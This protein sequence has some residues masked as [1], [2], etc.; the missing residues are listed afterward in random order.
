MRV[1]YEF[2]V[3]VAPSTVRSL[4]TDVERSAA[5]VPGVSLETSAPGEYGG[6]LR[7]RVG[8][9]TVTYRGTATVSMTE[10]AFRLEFEGQEARGSGVAKGAVTFALA[11]DQQR[12][13]VAVDADVTVTGRLGSLDSSVLSDAIRRLFVRFGECVIAAVAVEEPDIET[14]VGPAQGTAGTR[15]AV[16]ADMTAAG[17]DD[18]LA[19][20]G[21]RPGRPL[22]PVLLLLAV[23]AAVAIAIQVIRR[24]RD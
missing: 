23:A 14:V 7:L 16:T 10:D 8:S 11:G 6:R 22:R 5:C 20:G 9:T 3:E 2:M 13:R 15:F 12:T 18:L 1:E 24:W 4:L 21:Q 19:E 17:D